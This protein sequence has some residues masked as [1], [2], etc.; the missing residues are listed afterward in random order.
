MTQ[1]GDPREN[2]AAERINGTIKNEFDRNL[3]LVSLEESRKRI[4]R[5]I[6][7]YNNVSPYLSVYMN[8]PVEAH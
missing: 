8:T 2:P 4:A 3:S 7:V 1:N 5:N 6:E